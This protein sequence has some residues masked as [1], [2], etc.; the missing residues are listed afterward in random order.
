MATIPAWRARTRIART[1]PNVTR[2][3]D[4]LIM[5]FDGNGEPMFGRLNTDR[6]HQF[7]FN[8]FYQ[9]PEPDRRRR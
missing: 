2:L 3:F 8:G 1:A 7:K 5:A 9:L 4:G 6:P